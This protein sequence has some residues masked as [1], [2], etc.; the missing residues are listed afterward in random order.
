M[1][2]RPRR[3]LMWRYAAVVVTL[4]AIAIMSIGISE[5]YFSYEDS[6]RAISDVEAD[7]ASTAAFSIGQFMQEILGDLKQDATAAGLTSTDRH[8]AF[9]RLLS[10]DKPIS[11]LTYLNKDGIPCVRAFVLGANKLDTLPRQLA[12]GACEDAP[13]YPSEFAGAQ[14]AGEY[15]GAVFYNERDSRP[16]ITIAVSELAPGEAT[17][18]SGV[19]VADVDLGSVVDAIDR[20]QI[21]KAGYAYVVDAKGEL[22]A[23]SAKAAGEGK[24]LVLAHTSFAGLPQVAAALAAGGTSPAVVS[25]GRDPGGTEVLS[26]YQTVEPPGWRVFV[27][28]PSSEAFAPIQAAI[29]RTA[30]L[31]VAFLSW[32]AL[33][34]SVLLARNLVR[35]IESIQVGRGQDRLRLA[36]P[37]DRGL[38]QRR[39]RRPGRRVQPDGCPSPGVLRRP[40]EGGPGADPGARHRARRAGREV[41]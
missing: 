1:A 8:Q 41:A 37:A 18:R 27:E 20:A 5:F 25:S 22:I 12:S 38:E 11:A 4:V 7:K 2:K 10:Q 32:L 39:A 31:L 33:V 24:N 23:H 9:V 13:A 26:A 19:V 16:H 36:R 6:R 3:R 15:F 35:P 34:T 29:W 21:G 30:L 40:R 28:E 17:G 14:P